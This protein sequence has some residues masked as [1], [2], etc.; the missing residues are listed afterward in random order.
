MAAVS[1]ETRQ[2]HT[3]LYR[4]HPCAPVSVQND[5]EWQ[6]IILAHHLGHTRNKIELVQL[7][8]V[9]WNRAERL[10]F[11]AIST[12]LVP[13]TKAMILDLAKNEIKAFFDT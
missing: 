1:P 12:S 4:K 3:D 7:E 8:R 5:P 13:R 2:N 10:A 9:V 6:D 11:C